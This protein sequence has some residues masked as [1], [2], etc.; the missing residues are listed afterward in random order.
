M[1]DL[2]ELKLYEGNQSLN[3]LPSQQD[4]VPIYAKCPNQGK[5][6]FCPGHCHKIIGW[7]DKTMGE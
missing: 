6:C 2:K 5:P 7:R 1:Q 4:K 3:S